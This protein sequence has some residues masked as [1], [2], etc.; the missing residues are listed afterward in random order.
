MP[1]LSPPLLFPHPLHQG[2][3][4]EP[5]GRELSPAPFE[6][7]A[8]VSLSL[9]FHCLFLGAS[10]RNSALQKI[11]YGFCA[12]FLSI[13]CC[14]A[15]A[16]CQSFH[17]PSGG[18][19]I[20]YRWQCP[21]PIDDSHNGLLSVWRTDFQQLDLCFRATTHYSGNQETSKSLLRH[22]QGC[23]LYFHEEAWMGRRY[24]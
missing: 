1:V 5:T 23:V 17:P 3:T 15:P 2:G 20:E 13:V 24:K 9:G 4:E 11:K 14:W 16:F 10:G 21:F 19:K 7:W 6:I 8:S 12:S 22:G 18:D